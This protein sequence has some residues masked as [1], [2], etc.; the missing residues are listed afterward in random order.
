MWRLRRVRPRS[1]QSRHRKNTNY[2]REG[3]GAS[4]PPVLKID[5]YDTHPVG[6][7]AKFH[8]KLGNVTVVRSTSQ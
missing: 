4:P 1:V 6:K 5:R 3:Q 8:L 2:V 7:V